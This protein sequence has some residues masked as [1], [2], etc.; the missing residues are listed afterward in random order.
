MKKKLQISL[1]FLILSILF[2][3]LS[4]S[5]L[6][7]GGFFPPVY[8]NEDIYEPTQKGLIIFDGSTEKLIIEATYEG[9][10]TADERFL[11]IIGGPIATW[12]KSIIAFIV[13]LIVCKKKDVNDIEV[14]SKS[15][16]TDVL[17]AIT[18]VSGRF[19]FNAGGHILFYRKGLDEYKIGTH[20]GIN[21]DIVIYGSAIVALIIILISIPEFVLYIRHCVKIFKC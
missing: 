12:I 16:S 9:T 4:N 21:P 11:F 1:M 5:V 14:D 8:Y 3:L 13:L 2:T 15:I 17:L 19:I 20:L 18:S 7:D 6:A 10:M